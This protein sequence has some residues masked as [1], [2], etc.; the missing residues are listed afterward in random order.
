MKI[1]YTKIALITG[2]TS[3]I[4]MA[5]AKI[6]AKNG[7][8]LIVTGRRAEKLAALKDKLSHK[9]GVKI[10]TLCFDIRDAQA[11]LKAWNSLDNDWQKI[12]VLIN[13][14]GLAKGFASI[15][16][17]K[18]EDWETMIDTNL[19]GLLYITRLVTPKMVEQNSGQIINVCSTAGHDV[20][21][22]G[23]VYSATKFAV[24]ALTKSLRLDLYK[25]H[26]RVGQVSPGHVEETEFALVRFDGDS[27]K[28]K[29]YQDFTPLKAKD[30]ANA[31]YF[32]ISQPKYV[33]IQHILLMGTQQAGS[34][35]IDRSGRLEM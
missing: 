26:I 25:H 5:T 3:G 24:D 7:Y 15:H 20:Y 30:V 2:A 11:V 33:N 13:N 14:A 31:I 10:Q 8:N 4:G 12:D 29:I 19:K 34:N 23:N 18:L 6:M 21:P 17:G 32:M 16:E 9:Y 35:F 28:A 1:P 27:E 22:N